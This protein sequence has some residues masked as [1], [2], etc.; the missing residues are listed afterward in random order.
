MS[1]FSFKLARFY[2]PISKQVKKICIYS[3]T[4]YI[5]LFK[6]LIK[7]ENINIYCIWFLLKSLLKTF[8]VSYLGKMKFGTELNL[9]KLP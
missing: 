5:G 9:R 1:F 7:E 4:V 2:K 8:K 6:T 3:Y